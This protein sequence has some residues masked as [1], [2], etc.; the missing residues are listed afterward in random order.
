MQDEN[1]VAM[2][3]LIIVVV[4][5]FLLVLV[6]ISVALYRRHV[7]KMQQIRKVIGNWVE[8]DPEFIHF[9]KPDKWELNRFGEPPHCVLL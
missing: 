5:T 3:W 6:V 1:S 9:Y 7:N 2:L 8:E 4:T